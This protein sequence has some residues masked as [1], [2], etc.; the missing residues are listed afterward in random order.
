MTRVRTRSAALPLLFAGL[1]LAVAAAGLQFPLFSC[2]P[3][4][5]KGYQTVWTSKGTVTLY[6]CR[7]CE[8]GGRIRGW[9][10]LTAD[11]SPELHRGALTATASFSP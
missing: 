8:D 10:R 4:G 9:T 7:L 1:L 2:P 11:P 3:C 6:H 5:G